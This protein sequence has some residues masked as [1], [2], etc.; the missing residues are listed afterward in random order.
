MSKARLY[1]EYST[2]CIERMILGVPFH[3][4][5]RRTQQVVS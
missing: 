3:E 4:P 2:R 1:G 5:L